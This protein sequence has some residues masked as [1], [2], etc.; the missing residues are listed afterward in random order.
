MHVQLRFAHSANHDGERQLLVDHL[1]AQVWREQCRGAAPGET[2][3]VERQQ[4]E[5][6]AGD[7]RK[8]AVLAVLGE[9]EPVEQ[10]DV[11][12]PGRAAAAT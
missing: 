2:L 3:P 1:R 11:E 10:A 6:A 8:I 9:L 4:R 7:P 12:R 5:Q